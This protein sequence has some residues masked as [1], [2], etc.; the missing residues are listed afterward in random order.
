MVDLH[1]SELVVVREVTE[2]VTRYVTAYVHSHRDD[3][4]SCLHSEMC[5]AVGEHFVSNAELRKGSRDK[6]HYFEARRG[7]WTPPVQTQ[8][9]VQ[10]VNRVSALARVRWLFPETPTGNQYLTIS[11]Y[12]CVKTD[13]GWKVHLSMLPSG[14]AEALVTS[15]ST[16]QDWTEVERWPIHRD[17]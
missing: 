6:P 14:N 4:R 8:I 11:L 1:P 10:P 12:L 17:S 9:S 15:N 2:L 16:Y 5:T 3:F 7:H 13:D